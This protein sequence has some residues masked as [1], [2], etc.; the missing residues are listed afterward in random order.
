MTE[1]LILGQ[2]NASCSE[3]IQ[4]ESL[5]LHTPWAE[6]NGNGVCVAKRILGHV[7]N[8]EARE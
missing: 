7:E 1:L 2:S 6:R 5:V 3:R 8:S 4:K